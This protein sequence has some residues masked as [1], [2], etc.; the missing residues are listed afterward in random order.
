LRARRELED[1]AF[2]RQAKKRL[3]DQITD[4]MMYRT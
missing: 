2:G 3:E 1:E 4:K